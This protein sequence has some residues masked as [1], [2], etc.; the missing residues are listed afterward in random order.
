[1]RVQQQR[2][3]Q[4]QEQQ[5]GMPP[6][7]SSSGAA[8]HDNGLGTFL[9]Q[10][11]AAVVQV[12]ARD[13]P[14]TA[15]QHAGG[16]GNGSRASSGFRHAAAPLATYTSGL[17]WGFAKLH[18][19]P[20]DQLLA[21]CIEGFMPVAAAADEVSLTQ[22]VWCLGQLQVWPGQ[23][24]LDSLA[25]EV[26]HR[27]A[28]AEQSEQHSSSDGGLYSSSG[29]SSTLEAADQQQQQQPEHGLAPSSSATAAAPA[30]SPRA[31]SSILWSFAA[32]GHAPPPHVLALVWQASEQGLAAASP[33][34]LA[35]MAWAA[36]SLGLAPS[37]SWMEAWTAAAAAGLAEW[38]CADLAHAAWAL[39]KFAN[40]PQ[41]RCGI[42]R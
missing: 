9:Q 24:V 42:A 31:L 3:Q 2:I 8:A 36:A 40:A 11:E 16:N 14:A 15:Q 20:S 29:S 27:L 5:H 35:N 12:L 22:L 38:N 23:E 1:M 6:S 18:H 28:P 33:Q 25:A 17:L 26:G 7:A 10:L 13:L 37:R 19:A 21:L 4:Q 34:T 41:T 32:L 39:G 30:L